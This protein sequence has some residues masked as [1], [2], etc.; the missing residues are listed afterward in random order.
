MDELNI[1]KMKA[2]SEKVLRRIDKTQEELGE[3]IHTILN[4]S[5]QIKSYVG[6]MKEILY[7]L[8]EARTEEE[9]KE[10]IQFF[11]QSLQEL[12]EWIVKLDEA[13]HRNEE[14]ITEEMEIAVQVKQMIECMCCLY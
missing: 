5:D 6:T 8:N 13:S 12:E 11:S 1:L 14:G 9:R 7:V 3:T 4:C 2:G 10:G